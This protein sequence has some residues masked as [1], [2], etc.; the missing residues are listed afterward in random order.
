MRRLGT[1]RE[2]LLIHRPGA[3]RRSK[4]GLSETHTLLDALYNLLEAD[5]LV[6][7]LNDSALSYLIGGAILQGSEI[8]SQKSVP[9]TVL[10][11]LGGPPT[12]ARV[13]PPVTDAVDQRA[14]GALKCVHPVQTEARP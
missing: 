8:L 11:T 9:S 10:A 7:S 5:L 2:T 4:Q 3:L 14:I 6:Q 12:S 13:A 1:L